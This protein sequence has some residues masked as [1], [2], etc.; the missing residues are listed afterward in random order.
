MVTCKSWG[1]LFSL[2]RERNWAFLF[3]LGIFNIEFLVLILPLL[4]LVNLEGPWTYLKNG[5]QATA[6]LY[7]SKVDCWKSEIWLMRYGIGVSQNVVLWPLGVLETL[8]G[9]PWNQSYLY[10][11][12]KKSFAF[13]IFLLY[14]CSGI[15]QWL[16]T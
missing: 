13:L 6:T 12:I 3:I 16:A 4:E 14:I 2:K 9:N 8:S 7:I 5:K 15:F 1:I 10:N 11:N